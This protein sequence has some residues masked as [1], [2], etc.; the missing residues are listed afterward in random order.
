M[1]LT[2]TIMQTSPNSKEAQA[3]IKINQLLEKS[4][5]RFFDDENGP[6]NI[7]LEPSIKISKQDI[8]SFGD[9]FES[10]QRGFV[11]F[12][13]LNKEGFP[14]VVLEAKKEGKDPLD[15]KEQSRKYA[16]SL[17]ARF[18]I[19]SNGN[20]HYFWD[21]EGGNPEV[22][23][24]FPTQESIGHRKSFKPNKEK[25]SSEKIDKTYIAL[26]QEPGLKDEPCSVQI[27]KIHAAS[28]HSY[29]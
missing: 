6:A 27:L 12:L 21:L 24:E 17:N 20:L 10:T 9:D 11:D 28:L 16:Q 19:L 29:L 15:G 1:S 8:D 7:Q 3:R 22:I 5:W 13:L 23:T 4:G 18:V 26:T 25:L 14:L 2:K